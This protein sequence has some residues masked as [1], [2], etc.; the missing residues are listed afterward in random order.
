[1]I[2]EPHSVWVTKRPG[3]Y[4]P[5]SAFCK[6]GISAASVLQTVR[7]YKEARQPPI[8]ARASPLP[9]EALEAA[10]SFDPLLD[11]LQA[12]LPEATLADVNAKTRGQIR[13]RPLTGTAQ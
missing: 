3:Y 12:I 13:R 1:V 8:R 7:V 9:A 5:D 11:D 6:L 10:I 4:T 2:T